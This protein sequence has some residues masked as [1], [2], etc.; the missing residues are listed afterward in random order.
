MWRSGSW[1]GSLFLGGSSGSGLQRYSRV[2]RTTSSQSSGCVSGSRVRSHILGA[3]PLGGKSL[4]I[5]AR[6]RGSRRGYRAKG[7]RIDT[8]FGLSAELREEVRARQRNKLSLSA[9]RAKAP[10]QPR[11]PAADNGFHGGALCSCPW[12]DVKGNADWTLLFLFRDASHFRQ[13]EVRTMI[14]GKVSDKELAKV[15]GSAGTQRQVSACSTS[16]SHL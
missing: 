8:R 3:F 9:P 14:G 4:M 10:T 16:F 13:A 7:R 1:S 11:W 5:E 6:C 12:T 15:V 2:C